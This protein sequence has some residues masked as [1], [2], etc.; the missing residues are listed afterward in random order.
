MFTHSR[1]VVLKNSADRSA[2]TLACM[3]PVHSKLCICTLQD[4]S[5]PVY[6]DTSVM[7][8]QTGTVDAATSQFDN[9]VYMACNPSNDFFPDLASLPRADV[10]YFCSPNNPTGT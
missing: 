9:L 3:D 6:V 1:S 2:P 8:G 10:I 7:M 4:P 5:Y